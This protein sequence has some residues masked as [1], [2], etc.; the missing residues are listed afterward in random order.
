MQNDYRILEQKKF[1]MIEQTL[2]LTLTIKLTTINILKVIFFFKFYSSN[3]KTGKNNGFY[4]KKKKIKCNFFN[5]G[6]VI[7]LKVKNKNSNTLHILYL[8]YA[9]AF[10]MTIF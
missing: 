10:Y 3:E 7:N 1:F 2:H 6:P 9:L 4:K 5:N 8:K